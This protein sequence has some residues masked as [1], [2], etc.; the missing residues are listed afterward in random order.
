M[1][2]RS[3][4]SQPLCVDYN[5]GASKLEGRTIYYEQEGYYR[6][7]PDY[8]RADVRLYWRRNHGDRSNST[9]AFELQNF[10]GKQNLALHYYDPFR[11]SVENKYQLGIIPNLSWSMEL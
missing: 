8:F 7:Y 2:M 4:F 1:I 5:L 9:L 11:K 6:R 10:T 3:R